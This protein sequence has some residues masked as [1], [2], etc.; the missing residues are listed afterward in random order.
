MVCCG[1]VVIIPET[2]HDTIM[3]M[4]ELQTQHIENKQKSQPRAAIFGRIRNGFTIIEITVVVVV[5]GLL[6]GIVTI[7]YRSIMESNREETVK[8]AAQS[9]AT[10]INEYKAEKG[11]FPSS[12]STLTI[13][14]SSAGYQYAYN[15]TTD[16]YCVTASVK[17]ASAYVRSQSMKPVLGG[18]SGHG[19]NG[20]EAV[21][22]MV[23]NPSAASA[24]GFNSAGAAGSN[25]IIHT[26]GYH[27]NTYLQRSFTTTGI[28]GL[29][30]GNAGEVTPGTSYAASGWVRASKTVNMRAVAEWK[31]SGVI[32]SS[33]PGP[34]VPVIGP[35]WTRLH[36]VGVPPAGAEYATVTFYVTDGSQWAPG[37]WLGVDAV[38]FTKGSTAYKYADGD[39]PS[40]VWQG[41]PGASRSFGPEIK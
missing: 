2:A 34:V 24:T 13:D 25:T 27:G 31:G 28:G 11:T 38:M 3:I 23:T 7:S 15:P 5:I 32:I 35:G 41:N 9:A 6:V 10:A 39:S 36:T 17:G 37:D 8:A 16:A 18:C 20:D 4:E 22:N 26:G 33:S 12:L 29:Y 1:Q 14:N 40:W 21:V 19:V 30:F